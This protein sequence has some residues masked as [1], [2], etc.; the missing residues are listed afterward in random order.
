MKSSRP[1]SKILIFKVMKDQVN[2]KLL[3]AYIAGELDGPQ[4]NE[5]ELWI[6]KD[7]DNLRLYQEMKHLYDFSSQSG[8][9]GNFDKD[10]SFRQLTDRIR[11]ESN[12]GSGS[13]QTEATRSIRF[14]YPGLV[15]K[16]AAVLILGLISYMALDWLGQG[17]EDVSSLII[18]KENPRGQKS[19]IQLPDGSVVWLNAESKLRYPEVFESDIR[20]V[21]LEGE[22]FF[23]VMHNKA[24]PFVIDVSGGQIKVL[25][26]S[27]NVRVYPDDQDVETSVVTGKV[28]F[29]SEDAKASEILPG[30]QV[31]YS[32]NEKVLIKQPIDTGEIIAWTRGELIFKDESLRE[33]AKELER[34]FNVKISARGKKVLKCRITAN[35]NNKSLEEI[36]RNIKV[37]LPIDYEIKDNKVML[38]GKGCD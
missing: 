32:K 19:K 34:W 37:I 8:A 5:I 15:Y 23:D 27:F 25:G 18:S 14:S 38:T 13:R 6:R 20:K 21:Y 31:I 10:N 26:T 4:A 16:A 24:R 1:Y 17:K 36:L 11:Q 12:N 22:A 9:P 33:V 29:Q 2:W 28:A 35:F 3:A 30:E 7:R